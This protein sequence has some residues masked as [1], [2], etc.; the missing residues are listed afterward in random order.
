MQ[1]GL[2]VEFS[3]NSP[4]HYL[5][6]YWRA[7]LIVRSFV[8]EW[9]VVATTYDAKWDALYTDNKA[10]TLRVKVSSKFT[11][12]TILQHNI[13]KLVPVTIN[14]VL[15]LPPLPAKTKKEIS[16]ISKYFHP[17]KLVVENTTKDNN[18]RPG[19]SYA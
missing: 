3:C 15:P 10:N 2:L 8:L 4:T 11:L 18:A 16:T 1:R 19:K 6:A 17:K 14:K 13:P 9:W 5:I 12:R 7:L